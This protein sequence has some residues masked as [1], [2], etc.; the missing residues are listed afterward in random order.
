MLFQLSGAVS[1]PSAEAYA[2]TGAAS[3]LATQ[4]HR[5]CQAVGVADAVVLPRMN[6]PAG[7]AH[8]LECDILFIY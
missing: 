3:C 5:I 1:D 2:S 7:F 4:C 6:V 8:M